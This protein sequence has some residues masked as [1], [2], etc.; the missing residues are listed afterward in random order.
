MCIII[1]IVFILQVYLNGSWY[2]VCNHDKF[3]LTDAD[4]LC[5]QLSYTYAQ[6]F[7][8]TRYYKREREREKEKGRKGGR[9]EIGRREKL[10]KILSAS[11]VMG[12][13]SISKCQG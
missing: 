13:G 12:Y 9:E 5:K 1:T 10:S 11:Y 4:V 2:S 7:D 6:Y 8:E 3:R